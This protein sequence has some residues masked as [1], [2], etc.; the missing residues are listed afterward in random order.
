M[1]FDFYG[2]HMHLRAF[3]SGRVGVSSG[4]EHLLSQA[5]A[6]GSTLSM[7]PLTCSLHMKATAMDYY[8]TRDPFHVSAAE[9]PG[10]FLTI[11]FTGQ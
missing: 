2:T 3:R 11:L 7:W 4:I 8:L 10:K 9:L 1:S 5:P 6:L